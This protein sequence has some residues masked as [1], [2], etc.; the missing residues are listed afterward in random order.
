[1]RK[2]SRN[3]EK[4]IRFRVDGIYELRSNNWHDSHAQIKAQKLD[5]L[6]K[7][8]R[9]ADQKDM[10]G[11]MRS[12]PMDRGAGGH[13]RGGVSGGGGGG[14]IG[15]RGG[16]YGDKAEYVSGGIP[17]TGMSRKGVCVYT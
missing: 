5:V 6:H 12:Q 16:R 3:M 9:Q 17:S 15:D 7:M 2:A 13:M 8:L 4:R 1:M 14:R 10:R 11:G